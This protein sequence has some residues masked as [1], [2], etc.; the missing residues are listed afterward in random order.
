MSKPDW[1]ST[2]IIRLFL[3]L[4]ESLCEPI[5]QYDDIRDTH[6]YANGYLAIWLRHRQCV[7]K[8]NYRALPWYRQK[9]VCRRGVD[10]TREALQERFEPVNGGYTAK[11][12]EEMWYLLRGFV[13]F[14]ACL[15]YAE[16]LRKLAERGDFQE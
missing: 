16:F 4:P 9:E 15:E 6:F 1:T 11:Q 7:M 13:G 2:A 8:S 5:E 10:C 14:H 12:R 3:E